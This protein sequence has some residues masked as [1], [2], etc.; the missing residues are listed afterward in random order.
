LRRL[1]FRSRDRLLESRVRFG[2]D[3]C[4]EFHHLI[5]SDDAS[6]W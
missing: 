2:L 1:T 5:V 6:R 4:D 3:G